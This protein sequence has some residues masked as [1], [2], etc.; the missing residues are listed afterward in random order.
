MTSQVT[1]LRRRLAEAELELSRLRVQRAADK[2][3]I[4][5]LTECLRRDAAF[6]EYLQ[7]KLPEPLERP[8]EGD[9]R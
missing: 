2:K 3:S 5:T 9:Y 1:K 8:A 6:I 7:S 4:D